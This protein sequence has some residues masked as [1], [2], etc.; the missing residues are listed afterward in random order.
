MWLVLRCSGCGEV[1]SEWAARCPLC[2]HGTDDARV[3][4]DPFSAVRGRAARE[5]GRGPAGPGQTVTVAAPSRPLVPP[6]GQVPRRSPSFTRMFPL[7]RSGV[8]AALDAWW[9]G[10]TTQQA[11]TL[12]ERL[13]LGPPRGDMYL[14]WTMKGRVRRLT[15]L[16]WVPVLIELWPVYDGFVKIT[17]TPEVRVLTSRR[18]YRL[19][20]AVLDQLWA[21]LLATSSH[22]APPRERRPGWHML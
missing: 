5:V 22:I 4:A 6:G 8:A 18:Y 10:G 9:A 16:H 19:G 12:Q 11:V 20:H 3:C 2:H 14:G 13:Q 7:S 17:M 1:V 21:E 15:T